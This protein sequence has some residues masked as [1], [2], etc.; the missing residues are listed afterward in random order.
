MSIFNT[1]KPIIYKLRESSINL[2]DI[3]YTTDFSNDLCYPKLFNG[4]NHFAFQN[5]LK[6]IENVEKYKKIISNLITEPFNIYSIQPKDSKENI[7]I[8]DE[9]NNFINKLDTKIP[10][11]ENNDF[12]KIWELILYFELISNKNK[13]FTS[14][15]I[16][17]S[18]CEYIKPVII[19]RLN[20]NGDLKK[21]EFII[22]N[23]KKT[24][25]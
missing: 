6:Y 16:T 12:M 22:L 20:N 24:K 10:K 25:Y 3:E 5:M 8:L 19:N 1:F 18:Y 17:D 14:I 2:E 11:I 13:K 15:H 23:E 7:S 21:D 4:Y 9:T